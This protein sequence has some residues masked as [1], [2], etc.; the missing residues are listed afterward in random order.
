MNEFPKEVIEKLGYY[1]YRLIDPRNGETFYVGKGKGNR[2]FQHVSAA[3]HSLD[4]DDTSDK[5]STI[6][7]I[8]LAGLEVLHVVHR[9][10]M[11]EDTAFAVEAALIDAYPGVTN[12]VAGT[13]SNDFG[14]ANAVEIVRRYAAPEIVFGHKCLLINVNRSVAEASLYNAVR[15]CWK[16]DKGKAEKAEVVLATIQGLVVG[17]YIPTRWD[18]AT[19]ANFPEFGRDVEGRIAFEGKEAPSSIRDQYMN[20]RV[21]DEMRKKGAA[22]PCKYAF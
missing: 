8:H 3:K 13:G 18:A 5:I 1:V 9:H 17:V 6:H 14:P 21:P 19:T 15:F 16:L 2:L 20:H 10:G 4:G 7:E 11:D 22:N 12:I